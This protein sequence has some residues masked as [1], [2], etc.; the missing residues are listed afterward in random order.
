M[1]VVE[2]SQSITNPL[3]KPKEGIKTFEHYLITVDDYHKMI[4]LGVYGPEDKLELL[5]GELYHK[6]TI[7]NPHWY[8][9][10]KMHKL[11]EKLI[12]DQS[13]ISLQNPV[14]MRPVSE[15]EPDI[16]VLKPYVLDKAKKPSAK[17][18]FFIIEV[19][20]SS[21]D[22]DRGRKFT[23]YAKHGIPEY[24]I[25]NLKESQIEI[26]TK[27]KNEVYLSIN[28]YHKDDEITLP[29]FHKS[30]IV[31]DILPPETNKK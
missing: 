20:E 10:T 25:V 29:T 18:V 1:N 15:P 23:L 17:D 9:V 12:G 26:Y 8:V 14:T 5:E 13:I 2:S 3:Q 27:P 7:G 30:I 21:L 11:L 19:A 16:A 31:R 4:D 28:V 6:M 22:L 24:W